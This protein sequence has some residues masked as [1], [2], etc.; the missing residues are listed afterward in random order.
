MGTL[1]VQ[2]AGTMLDNSSA[3]D[4]ASS[5]KIAPPESRTPAVSGAG[6]FTTATLPEQVRKLL[7]S[8][9]TLRHTESADSPAQEPQPS[10]TPLLDDPRAAPYVPACVQRAL[11]R[12]VTPLGAEP[13]EYEGTETYLVVLP[14]PTDSSLV[15]AYLVDARCTDSD[16]SGTGSLMFSHPYP[17]S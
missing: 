7:G 15:S 17:R 8:T 9:P 13:G 1:L 3:S 12:T 5:A 14:H 11:G 6:E 16:P 10:G 4:S 2:T